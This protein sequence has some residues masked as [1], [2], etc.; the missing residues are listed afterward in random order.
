M[1]RDAISWAVRKG[2]WQPVYLRVY[3]TFSGPVGRPAVLWASLL[4][5]GAGAA[6][7][8]ETAAELL[9]LTD[10]RTARIHVTI[11]HGRRVIAPP[12]MVIHKTRRMLPKWRFARGTPPHTM[13]EDTVLDLVNSARSLDEAAGWVTAAF[14]R[15]LTSEYALRQALAAR[16]RVRWRGQLGEVVTL[17]AGGTHSVLEFRYDRDVERA[18]GLP[19]ARRQAAFVKRDGEPRVPRP[20]L[21]GS[22]AAS[23][24]SSTGGSFT[25]TSTWTGSATTRRRPGAARPCATTGL[26]SPG[27]RARRPSRSSKRSEGAATRER[28][29]PAHRPAVPRTTLPRTALLLTAVPRTA[30]RG[31]QRKAPRGGGRSAPRVVSG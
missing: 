24:S 9:G 17:A 26:R 25:A 10:R 7:S 6:L 31:Q 13:P 5:A 3:A 1:T 28:C 22:T 4:Y 16:S 2:N 11:P 19:P 23:S 21:R 18:H 15:R 12:E 30:R 29:A 27:G 14:A 8:H 20:L